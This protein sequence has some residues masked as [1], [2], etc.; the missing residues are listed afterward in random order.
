MMGIVQYMNSIGTR[1]LIIQLIF[2][3][4]FLVW[5]S[6]NFEKGQILT[7]LGISSYTIS[8]A[9]IQLCCCSL[10]TATAYL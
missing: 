9:T 4:C 3:D 6:A 7:T 2:S 1:I 8:T 5:R 10:K